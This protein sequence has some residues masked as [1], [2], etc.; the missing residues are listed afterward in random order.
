[1][2][3][4]DRRSRGE[5]LAGRDAGELGVRGEERA[6]GGVEADARRDRFEHGATTGRQQHD[7]Y[8]R[9]SGEPR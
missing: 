4:H 5:P 9:R 8:M 6:T 2:P 3:V 1:V 7:K